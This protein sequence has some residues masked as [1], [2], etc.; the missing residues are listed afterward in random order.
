MAKSFNPKDSAT[1]A[2]SEVSLVLKR[3]LVQFGRTN[4]IYTITAT[5]KVDELL[6]NGS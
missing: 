4:D 6:L 1:N 5:L 3:C 2:L